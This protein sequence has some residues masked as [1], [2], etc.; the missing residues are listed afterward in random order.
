MSSL[1][2][3]I[4]RCFGAIPPRG[5]DPLTRA[6]RT[7]NLAKT[8]DLVVLAPHRINL[9]DFYWKK[10]PLEIAIIQGHLEIFDFFLM[11]NC[12]MDY[13][14][15]LDLAT[16]IG[17]EAIRD[18]I[19]AKVMSHAPNRDGYTPFHLA[20]QTGD[21][22]MMR[23][24]LSHGTHGINQLNARGYPPLHLA[25]RYKHH[26]VAKLLLEHHTEANHLITHALELARET[27][28]KATEDLIVAK[29]I[30]LRPS[31]KYGENPFHIAAEVGHEAMMRE[32]LSHGTHG[33]NQVNARGYPPLHFALLFRHYDMAELLLEHGADANQFIT[34]EGLKPW[35]TPLHMLIEE[36]L[37]DLS[38]VKLLLDHGAAIPDGFL[39][40]AAI[41][42][43]QGLL[44]PLITEEATQARARWTPIRQAWM[45]A[46]MRAPQS[47]TVFY[48]G[49]G[50]AGASDAPRHPSATGP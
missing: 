2:A 19:V 50:S 5:E 22:T 42:R 44:L 20:A 31:S 33:I 25:I 45:S 21:E 49:G 23:E 7:G 39:E 36:G 6:V 34:V 40:F 28:Q 9:K 48:A 8:R 29:V 17:Q 35:K 47:R 12:E 37:V 16:K 1:L 18:L 43:A 27:G 14:Y 30:S 26:T 10:T 32:L 15:A 13:S 38:M 11:N 24:L 4:G 3:M 41:F 46:V